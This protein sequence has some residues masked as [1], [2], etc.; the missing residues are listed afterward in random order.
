VDSERDRVRKRRRRRR[1][2]LLLLGPG[3]CAAGAPGDLDRD[4]TN[5]KPQLHVG[6]ILTALMM[7]A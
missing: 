6:Y 5:F 1:E 2:L 4:A 7:S 3:G